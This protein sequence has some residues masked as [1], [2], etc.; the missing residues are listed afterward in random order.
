MRRLHDLAEKR[1]E[2][3]ETIT[4]SCRVW[5]SRPV[6]W[7]W[8]AA[9][10][11][12]YVVLTDR[13]LMMYGAGWF[14]QLPRRRVLADRLDDVIVVGQDRPQ[15][16]HL[17]HPSHPSLLLKFA[18]DTA[19]ATVKQ[20]IAGHRFRDDPVS[21]PTTSVPKPSGPDAADAR[22]LEDEPWRL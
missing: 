10:Y 21:T 19:S 11:R 22:V 13:R 18:T 2:P 8:S 3:G 5:Y 12:D 16:L 17:S 20:A 4:G 9:R 15:T 6:R 7:Q 1:L 14:T